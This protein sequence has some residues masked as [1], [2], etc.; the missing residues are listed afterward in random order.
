MKKFNQ[1]CTQMNQKKYPILNRYYNTININIERLCIVHLVKTFNIH[2][3]NKTFPNL[4]SFYIRIFLT[5]I[6]HINTYIVIKLHI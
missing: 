6:Q 1:W 5:N 3:K 4:T 2:N